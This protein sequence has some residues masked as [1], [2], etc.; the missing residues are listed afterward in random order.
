MISLVC[1]M[2]LIYFS[3]CLQTVVTPSGCF[4]ICRINTSFVM[5]WRWNTWILGKLS[6]SCPPPFLSI[7]P[8]T[9]QLKNVSDWMF[10]NSLDSVFLGC[11]KWTLT[12]PALDSSP[13]ARDWCL[14]SLPAFYPR[15]MMSVTSISVW[16]A[17][18]RGCLFSV[19][20][21]LLLYVC[22]WIVGMYSLI[23]LWHYQCR[24]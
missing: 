14:L 13:A 19:T 16:N 11:D 12:S 2:S 1:V 4:F 5:K 3:R 17:T 20:F 10:S 6:R 15:Q 24:Y 21:I 22:L 9:L 8:Q 7:A 23:P 18:S